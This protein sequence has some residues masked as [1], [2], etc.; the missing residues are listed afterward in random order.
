MG[1]TYTSLTATQLVLS[2]K[3]FSTLRKIDWCGS[4]CNNTTVDPYSSYHVTTAVVNCINGWRTGTKR[5]IDYRLFP[6]TPAAFFFRANH[7]RRDLPTP[8]ANVLMCLQPSISN[9]QFNSARTTAVCEGSSKVKSRKGLR[10]SPGWD[11]LSPIYALKST[12]YCRF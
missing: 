3:S 11:N 4:G 9:T 6:V 7:I 1:F 8:G 2:E 12:V 5:S 10:M